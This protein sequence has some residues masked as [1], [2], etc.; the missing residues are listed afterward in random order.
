MKLPELIARESIRDLVARYNA[1]GDAGRI[2]AM[3]ALFANDAV[4]EVVGSGRYEGAEEIRGLFEGAAMRGEG[5]TEIRF[6]RHF[7]AT[8]QI[9]IDGPEQATGRCYFVVF[10]DHGPDHWGRYLDRYA[11]EDERWLF[12]ERRVHVDAR[13]PGGW[14]ARTHARLHS[15]E[16]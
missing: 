3:M 6:L 2:D 15:G 16:P 5:G 10:T 9:D 14:G 13:V 1:N 11:C 12:R 4:L 8:H 7:T